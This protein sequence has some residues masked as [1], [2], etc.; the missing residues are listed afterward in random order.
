MAR[1]NETVPLTEFQ[2]ELGRLLASNRSEDSYLAGGAAL[3]TAPNTTRYSHD[4]DYF[5]DSE[6]R[7]AT[8]FDADRGTLH[9]HGYGV[10]VEISQPGH[11]EAIVTRSG[12]STRIE[13]SHDSAWRFM[14]AQHS[15]EF[16]YLLHPVDLATNKVL[17][18]AG[19]DEVRDLVDTIYVHENVLHLGALVWA[20]VGKDPGFSPLS[21]LAQLR[22]RGRPRPE[23]LERLHLEE[24]I[25]PKSLKS[26]WLDALE[27]AER[28]VRA[29]P[30]EESGCL[31][32]SPKAGE[33]V[34]PDA[35]DDPGVQPHHGRPGGVL[36]VLRGD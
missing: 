31:Y 6:Q 2:A 8:A 34:D 20:A 26:A 25:D 36:P 35:S 29:R 32:F 4:L 5:H 11:I 17:A 1:G 12:K 30:P 9:E 13:W 3:L 27:G 7:V 14:P 33:F 24:P 19:R 28:F 16:G 22:R 18:L 15:A 10:E 21:L 23:E